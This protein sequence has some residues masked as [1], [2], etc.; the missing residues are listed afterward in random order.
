MGTLGGHKEG[1]VYMRF[2]NCGK[3]V[4]GLSDFWQN[5]GQKKVN[6]FVDTISKVQTD[7]DQ[8]EIGLLK[9]W[10]RL[11]HK[12]VD[13]C[14]CYGALKNLKLTPLGLKKIEAINK[15]SDV[16]LLEAYDKI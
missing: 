14:V 3:R 12:K 16:A 8:R 11:A 1:V 7:A 13:I 2:G 6:I 5:F 4:I 15:E 9:I 10:Q